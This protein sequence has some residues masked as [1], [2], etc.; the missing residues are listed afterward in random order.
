MLRGWGLFAA[1]LQPC[2]GCVA[3]ERKLRPGLPCVRA[4]AVAPVLLLEHS[5][6]SRLPLA[7]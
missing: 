4:R 2:T 7:D 6:G 5:Q 3:W 1:C